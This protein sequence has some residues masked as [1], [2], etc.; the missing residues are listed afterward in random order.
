MKFKPVDGLL[1]AYILDALSGYMLKKREMPIF[2]FLY[3]TLPFVLEPENED[4]VEIRKVEM[5]DGI[6]EFKVA[7]MEYVE[8]IVERFRS[9]GRIMELYQKLMEETGLGFFSIKTSK[10]P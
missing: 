5:I 4:D 1:K 6:H 7:K 9:E 10:E 3:F 2:Q 8:K